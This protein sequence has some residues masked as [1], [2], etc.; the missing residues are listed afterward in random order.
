MDRVG[1]VLSGEEGEKEGEDGTSGGKGEKKIFITTLRAQKERRHLGP[2][3]PR[4]RGGGSA[5]SPSDH[6]GEEKGKEGIPFTCATSG[7]GFERDAY[8][9]LS[10]KG[11]RRKAGG[12]PAPH[13]NGPT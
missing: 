1:W 13:K 6:Q 10:Q 2:F 12:Q 7:H 11:K 8:P 5:S 9:C 4:G 3:F